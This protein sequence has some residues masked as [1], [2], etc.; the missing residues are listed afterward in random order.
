MVLDYVIR[1]DDFIQR[2]LSGDDFTLSTGGR[3]ELLSLLEEN[4]FKQE[5]NK[6]KK[7]EWVRN[8]KYSTPFLGPEERT[9]LFLFAEDYKNSKTDDSLEEKLDL[10]G[11]TCQCALIS[12]PDQRKYEQFKQNGFEMALAWDIYER[13]NPSNVGIR[14]AARGA[15]GI[16][17]VAGLSYLALAVGAPEFTQSYNLSVVGGLSL[18]SLVSAIFFSQKG[19]K[20]KEEEEGKKRLLKCNFIEKRNTFNSF[21][22]EYTLFDKKAVTAALAVR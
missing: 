6:N 13:C 21:V 22:F 11:R 16:L 14:Y 7:S 5:T 18:A 3:Y 19:R 20:M 4:R 15:L 1:A 10:F 17:A 12:F 9:E 2:R 8:I